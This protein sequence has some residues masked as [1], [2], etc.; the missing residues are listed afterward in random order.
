MHYFS[1]VIQKNL[2][3]KNL[4]RKKSN[5]LNP[6]FLMK[7]V[8]VYLIWPADWKIKIGMKEDCVQPYVW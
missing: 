3:I 7:N 1:I 8:F 5:T 4:K 6:I 2:F